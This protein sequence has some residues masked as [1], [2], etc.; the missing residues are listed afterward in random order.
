MQHHGV[1]ET[2]AG[3]DQSKAAQEADEPTSLAEN[4]AKSSFS[5]NER[6]KIRARKPLKRDGAGSLFNTMAGN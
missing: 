2:N 3:A 4:A 6:G 1:G 5:T